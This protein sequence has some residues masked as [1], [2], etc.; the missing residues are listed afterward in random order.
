[1]A[2]RIKASLEQ[3]LNGWRASYDPSDLPASDA[4]TPLGTAAENPHVP[5]Q[6]SIQNENSGGG[7]RDWNPALRSPE[8]NT[9]YSV[10]GG[11]ETYVTDSN[12][13]TE[14]VDIKLDGPPDGTGPDTRFRPPG[15]LDG[16]HSGHLVPKRLGG[17]G[18]EINLT[19][20]Q[21]NA[22]NLSKVKI[23]ENEWAKILQQTGHLDASIEIV[24]DATGRPIEYI[25]DWQPLTGPREI[26]V[27]PN[28]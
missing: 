15:M 25:Y 8:P 6:S 24:R 18:E 13:L 3:Q 26:Q 21:G 28:K 1:V 16:D 17:P 9:T 11:R 2:Q 5:R 23:I 20:Q 4:Q 7:R 12:G 14:R 10:D 22:V 27:I 19:A